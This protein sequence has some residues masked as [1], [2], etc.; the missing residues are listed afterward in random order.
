MQS[1]CYSCSSIGGLSLCT[2]LQVPKDERCTS[3][4][5]A[6]NILLTVWM[7]GFELSTKSMKF[8]LK[9]LYSFMITYCYHPISK[10]CCC[11]GV[12]NP[13]TWGAKVGNSWRTTQDISNSWIRWSWA[14]HSLWLHRL[15]SYYHFMKNS[16]ELS[17]KT[18]ILCL[19]NS[20]CSAASPLEQIWTIYGHIMQDQ[21]DGTVRAYSNL[22]GKGWKLASTNNP[23]LCSILFQITK[24]IHW[25]LCGSDP[26]MLEVG[27]GNITREEY[28][29][30]FSLWALMKVLIISCWWW[31]RWY[32]TLDDHYIRLISIH[33]SH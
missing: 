14:Q 6:S 31:W 11:R 3:E 4:N 22:Y 21:V 15:F 17:T 10:C 16:R 32:Q 7:V 27:N 33:F 30:H 13:A 20:S 29:S 19:I 9:S 28:R 2:K 12:D 25:A 26:D 8:V 5:R 1:T 24:V 18:T 23:T